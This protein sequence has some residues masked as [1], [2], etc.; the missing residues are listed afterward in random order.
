MEPIS[1]RDAVKNLAAIGAATFAA[2]GLLSAS[3]LN[4]ASVIQA[5]NA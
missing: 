3:Q 1:R 4:A 2:P 5:E